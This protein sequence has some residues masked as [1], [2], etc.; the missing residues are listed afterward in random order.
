MQFHFAAIGA[1]EFVGDSALEGQAATFAKRRL[2]KA[3][4]LPAARADETFGT[5][6]ALRAAKLTDVG[7]EEA[8]GGV[9]DLFER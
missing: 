6:G 7:I 8:Y 4:L 1:F 5:R 2:D 3:H 9:G